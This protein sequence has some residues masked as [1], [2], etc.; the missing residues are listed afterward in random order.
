MLFPQK[1]ID[2]FN[3][4]QYATIPKFLNVEHID[5]IALALNWLV[6]KQLIR[7]DLT[8]GSKKLDPMQRLSCNLITLYKRH[9]EAQGWIYDEVNRMPLIYKLAVSETLLDYVKMILNSDH[10]GIHPRLNMIMS[11][12][13]ERWHVANWHQD[14]F[15][16]PSSHVIAYLPLQKTDAT[17]GGLLVCPYQKDVALPHSSQ[18][19]SNKWMSIDRETIS[20]MSKNIVQLELE[21]GDLLLFSRYLPHS[22]QVN[23]SNN[24]RFAITLRYSN[25]EDPFFINRGWQWQDLAQDG[26]KALQLKERSSEKEAKQ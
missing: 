23:Y 17:N 16:T 26:I 7:L 14:N 20:D 22:A 13:E 10:V 24:V 2:D 8:V 21:K 5:E 19:S 12:P 3:R 25:L 6:E 4:Q 15:Y 11:M 1:I 18:N 9:P